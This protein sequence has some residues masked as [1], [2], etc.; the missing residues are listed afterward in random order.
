MPS[1]AGFTLDVSPNLKNIPTGGRVQT[2]IVIETD[3][4]S[5]G[6]QEVQVQAIN[7]AE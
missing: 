5:G 1:G 3:V 6:K 4:A 2:S 7:L